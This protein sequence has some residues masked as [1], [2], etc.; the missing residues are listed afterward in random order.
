MI[1]ICGPVPREELGC[2][3]ILEQSVTSTFGALDTNSAARYVLCE[4][5]CSFLISY[6]S[7]GVSTINHTFVHVI[8]YVIIYVFSDLNEPQSVLMCLV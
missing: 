5:L 8:F 1:C 6:I 4:P 2:K 7:T 3:Q